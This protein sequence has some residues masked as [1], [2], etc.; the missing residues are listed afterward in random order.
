MVDRPIRAYVQA[1]QAFITQFCVN[2]GHALSFVQ[3]D[4]AAGA[5]IY[6]NAASRAQSAIYMQQNSHLLPTL[7]LYIHNSGS[8]LLQFLKPRHDFAQLAAQLVGR[9]P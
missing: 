3:A 6:T 1:D 8:I 2:P 7:D 9:L 4:R 5:G